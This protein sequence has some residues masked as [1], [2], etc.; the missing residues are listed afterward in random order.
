MQTTYQPASLKS[1]LTSASLRLFKGLIY[2]NARMDDDSASISLNIFHYIIYTYIISSNQASHRQSLGNANKHQKNYSSLS[3]FTV[4]YQL[5][6]TRILAIF[7]PTISRGNCSLCVEERKFILVI[8]ATSRF[9][10]PILGTD[11]YYFMII[12]FNSKHLYERFFQKSLN[13]IFDMYIYDF[14]TH[15]TDKRHYIRLIFFFFF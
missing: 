14:H 5:C 2:T 11:F 4:L 12:I 10:C 1:A 7:L 15:L 13:T 8:E 9:L 3:Y 6:F